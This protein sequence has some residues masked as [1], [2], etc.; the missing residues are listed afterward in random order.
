[1]VT[2]LAQ[3]ASTIRGTMMQTGRRVGDRVRA[4]SRLT[5]QERANLL[6][7]WTPPAVITASLGGQTHRW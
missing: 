5:A 3:S 2:Q 6:A 4:R 1:M 7:G